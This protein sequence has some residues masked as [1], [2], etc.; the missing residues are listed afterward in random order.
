MS[1]E[2]SS[3]VIVAKIFASFM[4]AIHFIVF[5]VAIALLFTARQENS[6]VARLLAWLGLDFWD[7]LY[8]VVA[9]LMFYVIFVGA[10][11]TLIAINENLMSIREDIADGASVR[12]KDIDSLQQEIRRIRRVMEGD[13]PDTLEREAARRRL[14]EQGFTRFQEGQEGQERSDD[15]PHATPSD[16]IG[17]GEAAIQEQDN[18]EESESREFVKKVIIAFLAL[19][20]GLVIWGLLART[21]RDSEVGTVETRFEDSS[22]LGTFLRGSDGKS[23]RAIG[24]FTNEEVSSRLNALLGDKNYLLRRDWSLEHPTSV[25]RVLFSATAFGRDGRNE[26]LLIKYT[27]S[28]KSFAV[29]WVADGEMEVFDEE[30]QR[31]RPQHDAM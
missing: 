5:F 12:R 6:G 4:A 27:F 16:N 2:T 11:V 8:L 25:N 15:D 26:Q 29:I 31:F 24:F 10:V 7:L 30:R 13:S 3:N 19:V 14:A 28:T 22:N 1:D 23:L 18:S 20:G 9:A 17:G 21:E